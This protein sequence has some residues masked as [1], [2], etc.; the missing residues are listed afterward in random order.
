M[1]TP[2]SPQL[3][4]SSLSSFPRHAFGGKC[5]TDRDSGQQTFRHIGYD[6][7]DEEDDSL[8]PG[9]LKDERKDEERHTQEHSHTRDDVDKMFNFCSNGVWPPSSPEA[10]VAILPIT[11]RSPV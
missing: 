6:D 7:T 4:S 2:R 10:S 3:L 8:K 1:W 5:Q 11:V 9:V